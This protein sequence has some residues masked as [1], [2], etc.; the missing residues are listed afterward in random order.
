MDIISIILPY[1][2]TLSPLIYILASVFCSVIAFNLGIKF[3]NSTFD[4]HQ[5][6]LHLLCLQLFQL[7]IFCLLER[8]LLLLGKS[9]G[10]P[11]VNSGAVT[12]K[13]IS[14]TSIHQQMELRLFH[15]FA[16]IFVFLLFLDL[17]KFSI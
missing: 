5:Y 11:T 3:S 13:T 2:T 16:C 7:K 4:F 14:N 8:L 10:I 12:I 9:T 1:A 6:K 15:S 17:F